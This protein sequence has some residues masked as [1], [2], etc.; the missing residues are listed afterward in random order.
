MTESGGES[1][2]PEDDSAQQVSKNKWGKIIAGA[3]ALVVVIAGGVVLMTSK[4]IGPFASEENKVEVAIRDYYGTLNSR[5]VRAAE[6]TACRSDHDYYDRQTEA[7]QEY[8]GK[9]RYRIRIDT[10][11]NIVITGD[12]ANARIT[13]TLEIEVDNK[14]SNIGDG[15]SSTPH[16]VKEDGDWKHCVSLADK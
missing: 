14:V 13:G 5:G 10:V 15:K 1:Q 12:Q 7:I 16:L 4:G 6:A 8:L 11:D 2:L 3:V 9:G